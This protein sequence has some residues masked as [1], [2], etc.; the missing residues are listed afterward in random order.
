MMADTGDPE[1]LVYRV[2]SKILGWIA[3]IITFFGAWIYCVS[4]YGFLWGFGFGWVPALIL[5]VIV[6]YLMYLWPLFLLGGIWL[7]L[8][9]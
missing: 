5:S 1:T 8:R 3:G 9:K 4:E 2:I 6:C 7:Y